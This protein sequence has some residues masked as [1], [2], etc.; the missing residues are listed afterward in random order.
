MY[1]EKF[2]L[3]LIKHSG[4][5]TDCGEDVGSN[6]FV[7]SAVMKSVSDAAPSG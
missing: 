4:M 7:T 3:I 6:T 1:K 2:S 5:N